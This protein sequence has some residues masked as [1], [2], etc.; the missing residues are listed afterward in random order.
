MNSRLYFKL[1]VLEIDSSIVAKAILG[2]SIVFC[3]VSP[4]VTL[5]KTDMP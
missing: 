2:N 4:N 1:K 5:S 3:R